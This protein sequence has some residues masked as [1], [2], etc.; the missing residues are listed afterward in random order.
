VRSAIASLRAS[1]ADE[2]RVVQ[3]SIQGNHVHL[4]VEAS[5]R[6]A[7]S[8]GLRSLVIRLARQLNR[9]LMRKG[10]VWADRW[11]ERALTSPRAVRHAIVYVLT[12]PS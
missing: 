2:F 9:L 8:S 10:P 5:D 4:L 12:N 11:H 3:F 6:R 1:R 7:L